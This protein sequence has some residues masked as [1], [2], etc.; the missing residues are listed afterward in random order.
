MPEAEN[1]ALPGPTNDTWRTWLMTG[2]RRG[3]VDR[4]R[5][6]G[7]H[8]GLKRMLVEGMKVHADKPYTWKDFSDAMVRQAVGDAI[9]SLP[10]EDSRLVKLAYFGGFSNSQIA[11]QF[12]LTQAT[13][14]RR[15]RRALATISDQIQHG[16]ALGRRLAMAIG[17][18]ISSRWLSDGVH[19]AVQAAAVASVAVIVAAQ[20]APTS[21]SNSWG[22]GA[23][24]QGAAGVSVSAPLAAPPSSS[25]GAGDA[26]GGAVQQPVAVP[27]APS[28]VQ[29][30]AVRLPVSIPPLP[31]VQLPK[32]K[33]PAV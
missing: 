15:L 28:A 17:V 22:G 21:P 8:L 29:A 23:E 25:G 14:Q 31:A 27:A 26:G 24:A 4:R 11:R 16:R 32:V 18:W 10:H 12:G 6:R 30:P 33:T 3:P 7:E 2:V 5:L 1:H 13:V 9:R 19:H 20:P